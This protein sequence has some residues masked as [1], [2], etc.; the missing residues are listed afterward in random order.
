VRSNL[1]ASTATGRFAGTHLKDW[2]RPADRFTV[3]PIRVEQAGSYALQLRYHNS[4]NQINLGISG[5][6]KWMTLRERTGRMVAQGVIQ[7]PHARLEKSNTPP[8]YSTP[9]MAELKS[10][11]YTLE[12]ND[13]YNMSYLEAN[14]TFSAA[15]G[16]AGPSN[17]FDIY[18]VRILR[19]Q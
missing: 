16:V 12:L 4:A 5:G 17:Q 9:L 3:T 14:A 15:G 8:V 19:I 7:L 13:F 18:G 1:A 2:G 6:V 11:D 10:G